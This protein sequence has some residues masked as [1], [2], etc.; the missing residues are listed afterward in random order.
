MILGCR[1]P[2]QRLR[3]RL[4]RRRGPLRRAIARISQTAG[5]RAEEN[6]YMTIIQ[7]IS[8]SGIGA[9]ETRGVILKNGEMNGR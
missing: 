5:A 4:R 3:R 1:A 8:T 6:I 9:T 7:E 2:C